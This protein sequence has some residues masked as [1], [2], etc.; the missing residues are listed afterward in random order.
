MKQRYF[1]LSASIAAALAST[2]A[3]LLAQPTATVKN[4][5]LEG[6]NTTEASRVTGAINNNEV[7]TLPGSHLGFTA[8]AAANHVPDTA[9]MNHMQLILQP[10][11]ERQVALKQLIADQHNP[12][13]AKFQQWLTPQQFGDNFGVTDSD[14][15]VA[16]SWLTSQGFTVNNVYPNKMQIDFSGTSGLVRQAFHTQENIYT[17]NGQKHLA[18]ATNVTIPAAL[19]PVVVGVMGLNDFHPKPLHVKPKLAQQNRSTGKFDLMN[20]AES[21]HAEGAA[22]DRQGTGDQGAGAPVHERCA[23]S[24]ALRPEQHVR[25]QHLA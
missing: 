10:S 1:I 19:Q 14:I 13:S 2:P 25:R 18:N 12:K 9:H 11:A 3:M 5:A 8:K 23:R 22:T 15:A 6:I 24:G 4:L 16:T 7:V 17:I 21:G 20:A